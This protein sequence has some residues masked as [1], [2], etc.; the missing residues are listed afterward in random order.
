MNVGCSASSDCW[1]AAAAWGT[2]M[3]RRLN[4]VGRMKN[5]WGELKDAWMTGLWMTRTG[6]ETACP[7]AAAASWEW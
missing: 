4:E 3:L 6:C 2:P 7:S 1:E 5:G